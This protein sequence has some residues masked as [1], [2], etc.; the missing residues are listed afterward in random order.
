MNEM[1]KPCQV[2]LKRC[3]G[4]DTM[5]LLLIDAVGR[6]LQLNNGLKL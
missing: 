3:K 1:G 6:A 4:S 2:D 5:P